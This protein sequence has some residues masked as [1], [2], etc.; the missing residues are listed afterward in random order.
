M[1]EASEAAKD[2]LTFTVFGVKGEE[3]KAKHIVRTRTGGERAAVAM[4]HRG[5]V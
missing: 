3:E 2:G 5:P 1:S 4:G